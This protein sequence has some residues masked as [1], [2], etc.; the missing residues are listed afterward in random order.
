MNVLYVS[1]LDGTLLNM[2]ARLDE[3]SIKELNN[4]IKNGINFTVATGRG[5]SVRK[6]LKDI[7]FKLPIIA[8]NGSVNYDFTKNKY[9]NIKE[10]PNE[11]VLEIIDIV[12]NFGFKGFQIQTITNNS[13][14]HIPASEWDKR[15]K[16]LSLI[17]KHTDKEMPTLVKKLSS[18]TDINIFTNKSIY[19]KDTWH[20]DIVPQNVSK[21]S[22]VLELKQKYGFD[23]ILAFG[24]SGNDLSLIEIADEFYAVE[25]ALDIVKEK[26]TGVIESCFDNGVIN[27]IKRQ[28]NNI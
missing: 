23:K 15:S 25:N 22:G 20:C 19:T 3:A 17:V 26:S 2:N 10:I 27:F 14:K 4:L 13:L 7:D 6:I 28:S 21:A 1:D 24:D 9:T 11:K 18:I 12:N 5:D 16:C 8:L